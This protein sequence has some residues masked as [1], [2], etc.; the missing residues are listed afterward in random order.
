MGRELEGGNQQHIHRNGLRSV[1]EPDRRD[2]C[3]WLE[4][5]AL[6]FAGLLGKWSVFECEQ[7]HTPQLVEVKRAA[8]NQVE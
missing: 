3:G 2:C 4:S 7:F 6:C 1:V 8:L 5:T